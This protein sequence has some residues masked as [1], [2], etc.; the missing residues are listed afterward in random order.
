MYCAKTA[1]PIEMPFVCPK[2]HVL[3]GGQDRMNPFAATRGDNFA[4]RPFAKLLSTLVFNIRKHL[5]IRRSIRELIQFDY[6]RSSAFQQQ[7][8]RSVSR[9]LSLSRDQRT[10]RTWRHRRYLPR[11]S[12]TVYRVTSDLAGH[13]GVAYRLICLCLSL[14]LLLQSRNFCT[15]G[16]GSM[17]VPYVM[18]FRFCGWRHIIA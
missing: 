11:I 12:S 16:R 13:S 8:R 17:V 9:P 6:F 2:R 4:M 3:S 5:K 1:E 7:T 15:C 10:C 14:S 18:Y